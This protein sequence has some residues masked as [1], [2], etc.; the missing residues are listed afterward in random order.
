[1]QGLLMLIMGGCCGTNT[2]PDLPVPEPAVTQ[3][4]VPCHVPSKKTLPDALLPGTL[5]HTMCILQLLAKEG[6]WST[7]RVVRKISKQH[8]SIG[9]K[10]FQDKSS[11]FFLSS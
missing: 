4:E 10:A 8:G 5:T 11:G 2:C 3:V 7:A 1:M 9:P 6:L